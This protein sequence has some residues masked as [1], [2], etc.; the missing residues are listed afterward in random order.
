M[1]VPAQSESTPRA[2]TLRDSM[3]T[4]FVLVRYCT[5]SLITG[6]IDNLT[7]YLVFHATGSIAAAQTAGRIAS[8]LFNYRAVRQAV[9]CSD[10]HHHILLPRYLSLVA[11]NALISYTGIRLL[12]AFTPLS[13]VQSKLLMETLMFF[14]N[15]V[16]Q[17]V[18]IFTRRAPAEGPSGI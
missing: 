17:R 11:V 2:Q 16:I 13:V 6:V 14:A 9:F 18:F 3:R 12:S 1:S 5:I 4:S 15:F 7:F 10:Q 8:M